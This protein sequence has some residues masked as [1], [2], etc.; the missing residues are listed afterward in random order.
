VSVLRLWLPIAPFAAYAGLRLSGFEGGLHT[1]QL[2]AFTP[3]VALASVAPLVAAAVTRKIWPA[4]VACLVCLA[5]AAC[6]VPR[7]LAD[8]DNPSGGTTIR[9]LSVNMMLGLADPHRIVD[10]VRRHQVDVLALQEFTAQARDGLAAAG[11]D[12]QLPHHTEQPENWAAGS[13][14]Y[15]RYPL[16]DEGVRVHKSGFRQARATVTVPGAQPV[17]L[18]SV[19]PCAPIGG[20]GGRCWPIDLADQ[21]AATPA[22][23]VRILLGDFNAT[24]DHSALRRLIGTG[25]RDAADVVGAGFARTWPFDERWYIP[26]VTIDH[27]LVDQRVGVTGINTY[28]M[29]NS[30]HRALFA[31]LR[32]PR[33]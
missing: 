19:H 5:L 11:L 22:G 9:V 2:L 27:V 24:L 30:D 16:G 32:L 20:T 21:P 25:Y 33:Q 31:T 17:Q 13:A 14:L 4:L 6:V 1:V 7:F 10:L 3:Y 26:A 18:E 23:P 29:K 12:D 8:S 15:S 28:A